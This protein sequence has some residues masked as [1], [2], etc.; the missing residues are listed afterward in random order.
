[1]TV[2]HMRVAFWSLGVVLHAALRNL[3]WLRL[4][5]LEHIPRIWET[6]A[7]LHQGSYFRLV[8]RQGQ[9]Y[10]QSVRTLVAGT[11]VQGLMGMQIGTLV[12][13]VVLYFRCTLVVKVELQMMKRVQKCL[14]LVRSGMRQKHCFRRVHQLMAGFDC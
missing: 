9:C 2:K 13:E 14:L 4:P 5:W 11:L 10:C 12:V 7:H 6:L 3:D 8:E 1:M